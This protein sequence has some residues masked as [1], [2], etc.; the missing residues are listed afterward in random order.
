MQMVTVMFVTG[1]HLRSF[2]VFVTNTDPLVTAPSSSTYTVCDY[3]ISYQPGGGP[4]LRVCDPPIS[5][6]YVG[7]QLLITGALTVSE[8]E[9]YGRCPILYW[10]LFIC[11]MIVYIW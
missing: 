5:G 7:I 10:E 1:D 3:E 2:N 4:A 11:E 8:V 6:R 9:V